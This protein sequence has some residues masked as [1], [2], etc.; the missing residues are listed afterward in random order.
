MHC[1]FPISVRIPRNDAYTRW[2][3]QVEGFIASPTPPPF[4]ICTVSYAD[5]RD[6]LVRYLCTLFG[7]PEQHLCLRVPATEKM[8]QERMAGAISSRAIRS[9]TI[10]SYFGVGTV[11]SATICSF[12]GVGNICSGT[13]FSY[14]GVGTNCSY[15]LRVL[16]TEDAHVSRITMFNSTEKEFAGIPSDLGLKI[17]SLKCEALMARIT[18]PAL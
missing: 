15:T 12:F 2:Y 11:C 18:F 13:I 4:F 1:L 7:H 10:C 3:R 14:F 8:V 16:V 9:G 5:G 6:E 17:T